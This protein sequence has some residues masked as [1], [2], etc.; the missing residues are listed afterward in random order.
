M[1]KKEKIGIFKTLVFLLGLSGVNNCFA[2]D[3][4]LDDL[5]SQNDILGTQ[6][7]ALKRQISSI[8]LSTKS[9]SGNHISCNIPW[10][11]SSGS[12]AK[13]DAGWTIIGGRCS[14]TCSLRDHTVSIPVDGEN[15]WNCRAISRTAGTKQT[16]HA[17]AVC[18]KFNN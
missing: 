17:I 18:A 2:E 4:L 5:K 7:K 8:K 14:F 9:I 3:S 6:I 10:E 11:A 12:I 16:Y 13:C 15:S 1:R